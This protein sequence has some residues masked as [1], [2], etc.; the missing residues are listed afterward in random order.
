LQ[1]L[2][3]DNSLPLRFTP[4]MQVGLIGCGKMGQALALGA[5]RSGSLE[6]ENL[7]V[8]DPIPA[9]VDQLLSDTSAHASPALSS[10]I[11][12]CE[13]L[14]L[15]VKPGDIQTVLEQ[16]ADSEK[17]ANDLLILSIAA[18]VTISQMESLV[19]GKARIIRAMPNTPA[20]VG[21]GAAAYSLG[22]QANDED[23][24]FAKSLLGSVGTVHEV[25]ESLMDAVTGISGSGPAYVFTFIEALADGALLEGIPRD[26]ALALA[27]QT[28]LGA[29]TLVRD[30]GSLPAELRDRVTSPGGT[31]ISGL[32]A[33]ETGAFRSTII[34]AV[35]SA[36]RRSKEL[37]KQ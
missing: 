27:T 12:A 29:A 5:I 28:V 30:S 17:S 35:S 16:V 37:G 19:A 22:S 32:A 10:L 26:Q 34:N 23:A 11:S 2:S 25:K 20:L 9:A 8:F 7:H 3:L 6:A 31:T 1:C 14:L 33:L 18:G 4:Y 21:E 15:C 13:V 36:T 24:T